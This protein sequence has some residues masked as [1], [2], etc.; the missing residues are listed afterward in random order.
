MSV[1]LEP[2]ILVYLVMCLGIAGLAKGLSGTGLPL[3]AVPLMTFAI[4]LPLAVALM[5]IPIVGSNLVQALASSET[6]WAV[7][8]YWPLIL[9]IPVG[10]GIGTHLLASTDPRLLERVMGGLVIGFLVLNVAS[11]AWRIP[12]RA[13]PWA[14]PLAGLLGGLIGG[15]TAIFAPPIAL[16]LLWTGEPK[17]R[18]VAALAV[19]FLMGSLALGAS[20]ASYDL[21]DLQTLGWSI[22][23]F[24]PVLLG[25]IG[26][27][28]LRARVSE[29]L[30]RRVVQVIL[31]AAGLKM[32]LQ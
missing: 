26:G 11:P 7:G 6:R 23:A 13:T 19:C 24:A 20:L 15:M 22:L 5:T 4:D 3:V 28:R 18:F 16:Y 25:Q 10:T 30:F 1:P 2:P 9:A 17:E 32:M 12:T 29:A 31:L 27:T 14:A 8:R 21:M